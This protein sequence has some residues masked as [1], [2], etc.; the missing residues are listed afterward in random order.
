MEYFSYYNDELN[1]DIIGKNVTKDRSLSLL[2]NESNLVRLSTD[3]Y[4]TN[5]ELRQKE[6]ELRQQLK[7]FKMKN[8][9]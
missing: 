3:T 2:S 6:Q 1:E 7:Q 8:G 9:T 4:R 5:D